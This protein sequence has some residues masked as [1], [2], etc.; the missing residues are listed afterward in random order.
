[1]EAHQAG[2][3][4]TAEGLYR[5]VLSMDARA[6]DA[7]HYLGVLYHQRGK[8]DEAVKLV[9]QSIRATPGHADAHSNLGNIHKECGRIEAAE[10]CYRH[11]LR[12]APCHPQALGNLAVVLEAQERADDARAAYQDWLE[13]SAGDGRAHYLF[14]RFLCRYP[15]E[16]EDVEEA[17][18]CFRTAYRLDSGNLGALESLGMSLYALGR[19]D[20]AAQVYRDW[21][22]IDALDPIARHMLAACGATEAPTR[23]DDAYVRELFDRFAASF[24]EQ[25]LNNLGYRA[26]QALIE[27][28]GDIGD[29][30][31][32]LDAGCG[33]GLC[34]PLLRGRSRRLVGVD[35]S[36]RMLEQARQRHCYDELLCVELTAH[37]QAYARAYDLILCADTL[38][39]FGALGTVLDFAARA[40]R[41]G[42]IVAF[43]LEALPDTQAPRY[44]LAPSGRYRHSRAY[45]E[46][47]LAAAGFIDVR[48]DGQVLRKE[49]GQPVQ[50]WVVRAR[51]A[52]AKE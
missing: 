8:S 50:G 35:L 28:L 40:L 26:P 19:I 11:A 36:E 22:A 23:A 24:D 49:V 13:R 21:A 46:Q 42:G 51:S 2:H 9:N 38:V 18:Q 29:R 3:L 32:T 33:T 47:C 30:L 39:Y 10:A 7:L 48:I 45:L 1:M 12:L 20:D 6:P 25:L 14:G 52:N 15:R 16:R 31:D 44:T 43:T 4:D 34:G 17:V 41:P 5:R 27:A 37:L